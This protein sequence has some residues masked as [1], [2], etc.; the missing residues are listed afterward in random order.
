MRRRNINESKRIIQNLSKSNIKTILDYSVEGQKVN[1][2][3]IQDVFNEI[4]RNIELSKKSSEILCVFKVTG[5]AR[6]EL[7]EKL[8][9]LF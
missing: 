3:G 9:N 7:L 8:T 2:S 1:E 4:L 5:I 6:F